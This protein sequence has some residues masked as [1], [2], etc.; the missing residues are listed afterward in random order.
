MLKKI[1]S[2][3]Y[4]D[5]VSGLAGITSSPTISLDQLEDDVID[6][7]L[8]IIKEYSL[9][10]LIPRNDL[11]MSINCIHTDC[12]SLDKCPNSIT[13]TPPQLHFEIPQIVNDLAQDSVEFIGSVDRAVAFKVYTNTSFQYHKYKRR[14][15]NK[16]YVYIEPTPNENNFYDAWIFNAPLL[17]VVSVIAIFKDPRQ[18]ESFSC[19]A[20]DDLE[21]YT[22]LSA[23]IKKRVTEK[24][25]RYYRSF[26]VP[27]IPNNQIYR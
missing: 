11:L 15:A 23:E 8:Q 2:A 7:R 19:C 27:P 10:N 16:P 14:G 24:K 26:L 9:R 22:F 12:K 18:L 1:T 13:Y 4:N 21:N 3:I 6:E 17:E 25:I 5:I 20:G